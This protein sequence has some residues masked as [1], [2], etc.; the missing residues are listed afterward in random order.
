MKVLST[1][2]MASLHFFFVISAI[3]PISTTLSRGFVGDSI[4]TIYNS[5]MDFYFSALIKV[6]I[7]NIVDK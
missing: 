3:F 2:I 7:V 5:S 1:I 4:Q 6:N